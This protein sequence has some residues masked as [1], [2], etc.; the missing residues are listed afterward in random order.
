[1]RA[2]HACCIFGIAAACSG[3]PPSLDQIGER[4]VRA[5]LSLA[6][7]DPDL[8]EAWRGSES[9]MPGPRVPV[10]DIIGDIQ[11]LQRGIDQHAN[12]IG[13]AVDKSRI[14]YLDYQLR[15]L[16]FAAGRLLGRTTSVDEQARDEF[17]LAFGQPDADAVTT[18]LA[19]IA[20]LLPGSGRLADRVTALRRATTIPGDRKR[21]VMQIALDACREAVAPV[22]D[23]PKDEGVT[24]RFHRNMPWDAF[25]RYAGGHHT[26]IE[27]ND[28]GPIDM[29]RALRLA[30]HEGYAGHHVQHLLLDRVF[31][32]RRWPELQLTPGFGRHLLFMEGAAEVGTDLA[33]PSSRRAVLYRERLFPAASLDPKDIETLVRL[34]ELLPAL[35]PVVTEVGRQYLE[36]RI[37]QEQAIERLASDALIGNPQATLA[38]IERRRARALVY[39]EG[40][41]VIYS[42]MPARSLDSL[43][44]LFKSASA[45]Q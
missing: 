33:M 8:V 30:C 23:L 15:A 35:L 20:R 25:A 37:K 40:R 32:E 3:A 24:I 17:G 44:D 9:L 14:D 7:H 5:A 21:A 36:T 13:S 38:F 31:G 4:Y 19:E 2:L 42:M 43:R 18:A 34:E 6:Q 22:I 1:M 29:S 28:D 26:T 12:D 11:R 10:A 45:V 27:V 41:R 16:N 39:G